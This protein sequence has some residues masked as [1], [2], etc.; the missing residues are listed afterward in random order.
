MKIECKKCG[1]WLVEVYCQDRPEPHLKCICR[2]CGT[3]WLE[4][5][6]LFTDG[7]ASPRQGAV[8]IPLFGPTAGQTPRP[9]E[10]EPPMVRRRRMYVV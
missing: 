2:Q 5:D 1:H 6:R 9:S 3:A 4:E 10:V 7:S 8:L